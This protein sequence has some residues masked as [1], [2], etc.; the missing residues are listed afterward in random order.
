MPLV[1]GVFYPIGLG[2]RLGGAPDLGI[3]LERLLGEDDA[4]VGLRLLADSID[5]QTNEIVRSL[6]EKGHEL[7][8]GNAPHKTGNLQRSIHIRHGAGPNER[9][10]VADAPYAAATDT[11]SGI[12]GPKGEPLKPSGNAFKLIKDADPGRHSKETGV[13]YAPKIA[14]QRGKQWSLKSF[15]E[16]NEYAKAR[17]IDLRL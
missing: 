15:A 12:Y 6:A 4:T 7:M 10:I 8:V 17:G 14:G 9:E 11:G 3:G 2:T 16:L 5:E 13:V 1:N